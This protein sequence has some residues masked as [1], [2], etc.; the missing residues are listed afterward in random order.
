MQG[1]EPEYICTGALITLSHVLT[2][3]HCFCVPPSK[4]PIRRHWTKCKSRGEKKVSE[5][6]R[7]FYSFFAGLVR[8][9]RKRAGDEVK[10]DDI[11][12]HPRHTFKEETSDIAVVRL[13]R[14]L[15]QSGKV[16]PI[17]LPAKGKT[18][19]ETRRDFS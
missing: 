14:E 9:D 8:L 19:T 17:C 11:R 16:A 6:H 5:Q 13:E 18:E 3:S 15:E 7:R 4:N 10:A 1:A 2:A 12:I